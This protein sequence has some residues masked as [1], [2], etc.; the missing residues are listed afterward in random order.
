MCDPSAAA[1]L[2]QTRPSLRNSPLTLKLAVPV[3]VRKLAH[4][5]SVSLL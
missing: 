3:H 2:S 1:L 5:H 4:T